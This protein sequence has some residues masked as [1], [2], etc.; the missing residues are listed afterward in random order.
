MK[1][2]IALILTTLLLLVAVWMPAAHADTN[3]GDARTL[4]VIVNVDKK[5]SVSEII[6]AY[7]ISPGFRNM[8][9]D[10]LS[11]MITSPAMR[12]GK[13]VSSQLV[14]TLGV[15]QK[16]LAGGKSSVSLKFLASKPLPAGNWHWLLRANKPPALANAN[17]QFFKRNTEDTNQRLNDM[18]NQNAVRAQDLSSGSFAPNVGTA[19]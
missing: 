8:V 6:P 12:D 19:H 5:G 15:V 7:R 11:K 10:T 2:A 13:P 18:R 16:Q 17:A 9:R 1:N 3:T 14:I 4:P